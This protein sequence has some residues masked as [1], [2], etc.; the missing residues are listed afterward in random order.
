M[1]FAVALAAACLPVQA[2]RIFARD[3]PALA[4]VPGEVVLSYAPQPGLKRVFPPA[5]LNQVLERHNV[6]TR[7]E[8]GAC[9]EWPMRSLSMGDVRAALGDVDIAEI[10]KRTVPPG[11]LRFLASGLKPVVNGIA[12][13]HGH[14]EFLPGK[15]V[16]VWVKVRASVR[17][18]RLITTGP[19]RAGEALDSSRV[20][21]EEYL[22]VPGAADGPSR[23]DD[24]AGRVAKRFLPA[25]VAIHDSDLAAPAAVARGETLSVRVVRGAASVS[26][27]G[28]A[29]FASPIGA[30]VS[31]FNP[32]TKRTVRA[33]VTGPG[34]AVMVIE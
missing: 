30:L 16:P 4:G 9:F 1:T 10:D 24:L 7:A 6:S 22:A 34:A 31:V 20:R 11:P 21:M 19:V 32:A 25:N 3:L 28:K 2:D 14:V 15:R 13:W 17:R 29:Q 8:N 12:V 18:A 26:F 5:E 27:E 23:T 33:R